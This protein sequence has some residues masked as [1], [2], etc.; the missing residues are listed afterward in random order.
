MHVLCGIGWKED[1]S[2]VCILCYSETQRDSSTYQSASVI[3]INTH[4]TSQGIIGNFDYTIKKHGGAKNQYAKESPEAEQK[5]KHKS[6][7]AT[8][9][10]RVN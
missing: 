2:F 8:A 6:K 5:S 1:S 9:K 3:N 4:P 10:I 7:E